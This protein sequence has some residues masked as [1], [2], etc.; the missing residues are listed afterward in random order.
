MAVRYDKKYEVWRYRVQVTALDSS[1]VRISGTRSTKEAAMK[2]EREEIRRVESAKSAATFAAIKLGVTSMPT[3]NE[4]FEGRFWTEWVVAENNKPSERESKQYIFGRHLRDGIGKLP[5]DQIT[6]QEIAAFKA[7]L[8]KV[9]KP[10]TANNILGV[11]STPLKY[12]FAVGVLPHLPRIGMLKVEDP[13]IVPLSFDEYEQLLVAAYEDGPVWYAAVCLAGEAGLRVGEV[14][15]LLVENIDFTGRCLTVS[16]QIRNGSITSPKGRKRRVVPMTDRLYDALRG[17][18][19]IGRG[20]LFPALDGEP[21]TDHPVR[22]VLERIYE[23]SGVRRRDRSV[24]HLFRHTFGSH[25]VLFGVNP[26]R[27]MVWMGHKSLEQGLT[28]VTWAAEHPWP[29]PPEVLAAGAKETDAE[30]RIV[31][32]LGARG[33]AV[34]KAGQESEK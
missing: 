11:V 21:Y 7:R 24:W 20:F 10:K 34:A 15:A 27:L 23:R 16:Q 12:A 2:A 30:R 14:K 22:D 1:R 33:K 26:Y 5:L 9:V 28:Y 6:T 13:E 17:L 25:A 18:G 29:V 19:R 32:M 3:F 4:W 8:L 31:A